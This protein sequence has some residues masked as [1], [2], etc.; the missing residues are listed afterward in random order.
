MRLPMDACLIALIK[1]HAARRDIGLS[2]E[3][4][5]RRTTGKGVGRGVGRVSTFIRMRPVY[6]SQKETVPLFRLARDFRPAPGRKKKQKE[7]KKRG[8]KPA[9]SLVP[10]PTAGSL[11]RPRLPV[12]DFFS[13]ENRIG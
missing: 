10:Q 11:S 6:D 2:R 8:A 9:C 13:P 12:A 7:R 5:G 3:A 1:I 4:G